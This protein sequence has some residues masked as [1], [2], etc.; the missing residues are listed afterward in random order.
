MIGLVAAGVGVALVP[1]SARALRRR[2]V[3]YR[4]LRDGGGEHVVELA[5]V[6]RRDD[7]SPLV[8]AFV[9]A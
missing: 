6:W 8:R 3:V 7:P 5:A 1:D 9:G 2:G 4:P